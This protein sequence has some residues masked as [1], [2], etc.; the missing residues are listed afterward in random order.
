MI[1]MRCFGFEPFT[2]GNHGSTG[3]HPRDYLYDPLIFKVLHRAHRVGRLVP[4]D[5]LVDHL[6]RSAM[7]T[8]DN[9]NSLLVSYSIKLIRV[10]KS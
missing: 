2:R 7:N 5:V 3:R 8:N 4:R 10:F 9:S 1:V 6:H